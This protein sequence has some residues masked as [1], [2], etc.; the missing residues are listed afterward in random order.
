MI[1][2]MMMTAREAGKAG[3]PMCF[4]R[5]W[6][7]SCMGKYR[8]LGFSVFEGLGPQPSKSQA[9]TSL[10]TRRYRQC[11][12]DVGASAVRCCGPSLSLEG[13]GEASEVR[14]LEPAQPEAGSRTLLKL[15]QISE[16]G[17]TLCH[18][19]PFRGSRGL[20]LMPSGSRRF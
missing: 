5:E 2:M 18:F 12:R 16:L 3:T 14:G 13:V 6:H 7:A 20:D 8:G 15:P 19:E 10:K 4:Q 11:R 1:M 17:D 9:L